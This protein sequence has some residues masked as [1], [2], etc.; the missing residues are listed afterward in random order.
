MSD[1]FCPN[2]DGVLEHVGSLGIVTHNGADYQAD[3]Y[4]CNSGHTVLVMD[5]IVPNDEDED[6]DRT[7]KRCGDV[8]VTLCDGCVA[9]DADE[10]EESAQ[11]DYAA[12]TAIE[13]IRSILSGETWSP[14]T[15]DAIAETLRTHGYEIEEARDAL[16]NPK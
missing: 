5:Q 13:Q 2:C 6:E 16:N 4:D 12:D 9:E 15:L 1:Y 10:A 8:C 11:E 7:C 14:S 3:R